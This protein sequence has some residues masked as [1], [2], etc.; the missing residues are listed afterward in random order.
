MLNYVVEDR[1][2]DKWL[3]FIHGIGGSI[4]T[5]KRQLSCF[6][7]YNLLAIDLPGHGQSN[8]SKEKFNIDKINKEIKRILN[9]LSIKTADFVALSLGSL[10][11]AHFAVAHPEYIHSL[12]MGGSVLDIRGIYK[13]LMMGV[14][15]VKNIIPHKMLYNIFAHVVLPKKNHERSRKIFMKES[16][17]MTKQSFVSWVSYLN[18]AINPTKL[19]AQLKALNINMFFISGDEDNCFLKGTKKTCEYLK[20]AKLYVI[21]RCGHV[22]SIEKASEFNTQVSNYLAS[23]PA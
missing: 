23:L 22:C 3:V 11:A 1:Q 17:K 18:F 8:F 21:Q 7:E 6:P 13:Y 15:M 16:L 12:V 20:K 19:L 14:Q 5:W 10:V 4:A 2:S 9:K